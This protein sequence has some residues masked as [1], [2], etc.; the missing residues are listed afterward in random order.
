LAN[1]EL[2]K[3]MKFKDEKEKLDHIINILSALRDGKVVQCRNAT[4]PPT[5]FDRC[6]PGTTSV[7]QASFEH[8]AQQPE[9]YQIKPEPKEWWALASKQGTITSSLYKTREDLEEMLIKF[10]GSP[11]LDNTKIIRVREVI[12]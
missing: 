7:S 10:E 11:S 3:V 12:E 1:V 4:N 5:W 6:F 8:I 2:N 9:R